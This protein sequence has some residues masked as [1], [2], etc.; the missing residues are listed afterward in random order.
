MS[1]FCFLICGSEKDCSIWVGKY[2]PFFSTTEKNISK[3]SKGINQ[4]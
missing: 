3:K 2:K 1:F 4:S